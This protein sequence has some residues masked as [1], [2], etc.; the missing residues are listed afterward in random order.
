MSRLALPAVLL[1]ALVLH[2]ACADDG[3]RPAP[4]ATAT[5]TPTGIDRLDVVIDRVLAKD[6]EA[7]TDLVV[8]TP[9]GCVE[10]STVGAPPT[11]E[12]AQGVGSPVPVFAAGGC[13]GF[14][15][16]KIDEVKRLF[17]GVLA[18]RGEL[19]LYAVLRGEYFGRP[20]EGYG[21]AV[22]GGTTPTAPGLLWHVTEEG[23]IDA[24]SFGCGVPGVAEMVNLAM[25]SAEYLIGP[26]LT[27]S[28]GPGE[29]VDLVVDVEGVAGG[30][31]TGQF[32]GP[33]STPLH[34]PTG[35]RA[36][37]HAT[38]ETQWQGRIRSFD[39][40]RVG[41]LL[42]V[43]GERQDDCSIVATNISALDAPAQGD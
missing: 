17:N 42:Q 31:S 35:E 5:P 21:V 19:S 24:L 11:C 7:L 27:C 4:P 22:A 30:V 29:A 38:L 33:A 20:E 10:R 43:T 23:R 34:E 39:K 1:A 2:I 6:V 28:P 37:V 14:F 41:M 8:F 32:D 13:E 36:I 18:E 15:L 16:T 12:P 9:H 3:S 40:V 25:P 26:L